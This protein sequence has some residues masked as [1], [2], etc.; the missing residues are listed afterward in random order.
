LTWDLRLWR[1]TQALHSG[2]AASNR[3]SWPRPS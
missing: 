3:A 1:P 2:D